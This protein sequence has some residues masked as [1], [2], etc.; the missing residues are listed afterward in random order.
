MENIKA[1]VN[2]HELKKH[3][4]DDIEVRNELMR[5]DGESDLEWRN[6]IQHE[7]ELKYTKILE[8]KKVRGFLRRY[9]YYNEQGVLKHTFKQVELTSDSTKEIAA[10][11]KQLADDYKH[12]QIFNMV[13]QGEPG[14]GKSMLASCLLNDVNNNA[15]PAM[16]CMYLSATLFR[17]L[18]ME[19]NRDMDNRDDKLNKEITLDN[20]MKHIAEADLLV[21]DDLGSETSMQ[22]QNIKPANETMQKALFDLA[23]SRQ[24]KSTIIT[25]NYS[26]DDLKAMYNPKIIDR[27]F[28]ANKDH[29]VKFDGIPSYRMLHN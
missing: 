27:I 7:R 5:K 17:R 24:G 22:V 21:L 14:T 2:L 16:K 20:L 6:R 3:M 26:S 23:D 9:S 25:T 29:V 1:A 28:T 11:V 12:G 18:A 4:P 13:L 8:R 10:H 15:D 19:Q